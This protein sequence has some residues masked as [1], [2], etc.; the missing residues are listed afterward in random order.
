M[1][2]LENLCLDGSDALY[3]NEEKEG[4]IIDIFNAIV[5]NCPR[6]KYLSLNKGTYA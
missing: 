1:K 3:M 6:L 4:D 2:N 5:T